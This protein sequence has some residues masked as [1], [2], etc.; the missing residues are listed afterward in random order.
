MESGSEMAVAS[1]GIAPPVTWYVPIV[2]V[3]TNFRFTFCL[4]NY[5]FIRCENQQFNLLFPRPEK[6][7]DWLITH[8]ILTLDVTLCSIIILYFYLIL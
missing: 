7:L 8:F 4:D 5:S 1:P 3:L 6:A 2:V